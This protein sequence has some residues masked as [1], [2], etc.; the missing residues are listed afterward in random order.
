VARKSEDTGHEIKSSAAAEM[1]AE[2]DDFKASGDYTRD[3]PAN[4]HTAPDGK[5][6]FHG[7]PAAENTLT[8]TTTDSTDPTPREERLFYYR[9]SAGDMYEVSISYPGKGDFT[10]RGREV[11][12]TTLANLDIDKP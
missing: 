11:A 7:S 2:N 9:T 3:M 8:Y 4:P 1:Y 10:A 5:A 6:T 12:R